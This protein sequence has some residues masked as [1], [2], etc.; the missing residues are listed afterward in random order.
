ME[1]NGEK[2]LVVFH[3][4]EDGYYLQFEDFKTREVVMIVSMGR[5]EV[6]ELVQNLEG[7]LG[8]LSRK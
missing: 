5:G 2:V 6:R 1:V 4:N 8:N 3:S 7:Q